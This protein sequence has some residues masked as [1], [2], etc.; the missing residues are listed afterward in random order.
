MTQTDRLKDTN[1]PRQTDLDTKILKD[2]GRGKP[3][4]TE[5][6]SCRHKDRD[7]KDRQYKIKHPPTKQLTE[8]ES[9]GE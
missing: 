8:T 2:R 3:G 4:D 9:D 7:T 5:R 1:R 6:H